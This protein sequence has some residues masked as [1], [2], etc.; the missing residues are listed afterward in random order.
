MRSLLE[1]IFLPVNNT[2]RTLPRLPALRPVLL[3]RTPTDALGLSGMHPCRPWNTPCEYVAYETHGAVSDTWHL[4][5][6]LRV[7]VHGHA[8]V[9]DENIAMME[10]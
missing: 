10:S 8:Q 2:P 5:Y 3:N 4:C 1:P 9:H 6:Q 7:V